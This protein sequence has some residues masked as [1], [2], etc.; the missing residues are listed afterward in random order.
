MADISGQ[1][2]NSANDEEQSPSHA[3]GNEAAEAQPSPE[4]LTPAV[5]SSIIG[6]VRNFF[7][8]GP[9]APVPVQPPVPQARIDGGDLDENVESMFEMNKKTDEPAP[10]PVAAT[11]AADPKPEASSET[12]HEKPK[13]SEKPVA[14]AEKSEKPVADAKAEAGISGGQMTDP[15]ISGGQMG[16][17]KEDLARVA[18]DR[19]SEDEALRGDL[20]DFGFGPLLDWGVAAAQAY[21]PK[22][23]DS[24]AMEAYA[25]R[26]KGVIETAVAIA[27]NGKLAELDPLVDFDHSK[28]AKLTDDLKALK[29]GDDP[30]SNAEQIAAI[31]KS[32]LA[33]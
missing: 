2:P 6:A 8:V 12:H 30:D 21:A 4:P 17:G 29:L 19:L 23:A 28:S 25:A 33:H 7:K 5:L 26:L 24:N 27:Q 10:T 18:V 31:L 22:A 11:P 20:T 16:A 14:E 3:H 1:P 32:A 15:G 13:N 9:P